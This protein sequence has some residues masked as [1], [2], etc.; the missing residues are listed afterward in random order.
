MK[1]SYATYP[2]YN[3]STICVDAN[4]SEF[5]S[6]SLGATATL[7]LSKS[8]MNAHQGTGDWSQNVWED[9]LR[10]AIYYYG[11]SKKN[12]KFPACTGSEMNELIDTLCSFC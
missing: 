10:I 2:T 4:H 8:D 6:V 12:P 5:L 3:G 1:A 7:R 9:L 11:P